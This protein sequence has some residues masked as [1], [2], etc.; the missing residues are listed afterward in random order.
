MK[1]LPTVCGFLLLCGT[2]AACSPPFAI[3]ED[4]GTDP[5]PPSIELVGVAYQPEDPGEGPRPAPNLQPA[6]GFVVRPFDGEAD[7]LLI[8]VRY[9]DVGADIQHFTLRD[10]DGTLMQDLTPTAP[11]GVDGAEDPEFFSGTSGEF[12]LADI[13]IDVRM[14]GPH[15]MELWAEDSHESRSEKVTFTIQVEL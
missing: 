4:V 14:F 5:H 12:D 1:R 8:R 9:T 6:E 2:L 3:F 7:T 10:R 13:A 11:E 15:R